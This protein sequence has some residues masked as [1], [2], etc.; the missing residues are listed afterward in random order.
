MSDQSQDP[1]DV[2]EVDVYTFSNL[3]VDQNVLHVLKP[4]LLMLRNDPRAK[5]MWTVYA[6]VDQDVPREKFSMKDQLAVGLLGLFEDLI[7]MF[8]QSAVSDLKFEPLDEENMEA[9]VWNLLGLSLMPGGD[10]D[11]DKLVDM[12]TSDDPTQD[13][14]RNTRTGELTVPPT[15]R[16]ASVKPV[17]DLTAVSKTP[18]VTKRLN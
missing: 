10:T 3:S 2:P 18:S 11:I 8:V 4:L 1:F 9:L 13:V 16:D 12:W 17:K 14:V 7:A 6:M 5:L 15:V